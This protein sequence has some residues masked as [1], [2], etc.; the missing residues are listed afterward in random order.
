MSWDWLF[1]SS[2]EVPVWIQ[3]VIEGLKITATFATILLITR[4]TLSRADRKDATARLAKAL[5]EYSDRRLES[6]YAVMACLTKV[7]ILLMNLSQTAEQAEQL[8]FIDDDTLSQSLAEGHAE[9]SDLMEE[10]IVHMD[11]YGHAPDR[12]ECEWLDT[13]EAF[14]GWTH[15]YTRTLYGTEGSLQQ[16]HKRAYG[17]CGDLQSEIRLLILTEL[18]MVLETSQSPYASNLGRHT[19][20]VYEG[21]GLPFLMKGDFKEFNLIRDSPLTAMVERGIAL[22]NEKRARSAEGS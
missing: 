8:E 5:S 19:R 6:L 3:L 17:L 18:E 21:G 7:R 15:K 4:W 20:Q 9:I 14:V 12:V 22:E 11:A 1:Q 2:R 10:I 13:G 16:R